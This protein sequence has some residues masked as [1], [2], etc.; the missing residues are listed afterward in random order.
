MS[1]L[2]SILVR[3]K[4]DESFVAATLRAI[5]DQECDIPFEVVCCDDA[6]TDRTPE[7]I[8]T[9]PQ[10]TMLPR[11]PGEY[12]P[13]QRL[14]YM[15][16]HSRGDL[17]VFNNADAIPQNHHWLQKLIA[18]LLDHSA[19]AAYG[20]QLPR[21]DA[22]WLV[23]KDHL[24]AFGD[25]RIAAQW[26]FFFSLAT[27]A[28]WKRDLLDHPFDETIRYSEDVEWA[29]R[30]PIRIAYAPEA[31]VE[32]SHNYTLAQLRRRFHGE[33]EADARI[34][35]PTPLWRELA[36]ALRET[37]RDFAYLLPRPRAWRE[38]PIAPIRRLTQRYCHWKGGQDGC[39]AK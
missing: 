11:P 32:H 13:G 9:F 1:H 26:R 35:G 28:A 6:S 21:P 7:L 24:R 5:F 4:N 29:H 17:I 8:A 10:A 30:R 14:N 12:Y 23:R 20:N 37:L 18:P 27:A 31:L 3:S 36:S 39:D 19:D 2:V 22:D 25:G 38:L 16:A 15:V 33:G 34:F